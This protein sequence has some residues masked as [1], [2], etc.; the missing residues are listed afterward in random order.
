MLPMFNAPVLH[1]EVVPSQIPQHWIVPFEETLP[2][3]LERVLIVLVEQPIYPG[4]DIVKGPK[5][6]PPN[7]TIL[8][9]RETKQIV[10]V[11]IWRIRRLRYQ[12]YP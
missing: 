7:T 6:F 1:V 2:Y 11:E 5:S 3:K 8:D 12:C 10:D 4:Y 9:V